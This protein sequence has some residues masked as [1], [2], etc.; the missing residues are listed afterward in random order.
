MQ[1]SIP[2]GK[3]VRLMQ[4][5]ENL[6]DFKIFQMRPID[7]ILWFNIS[8]SYRFRDWIP[9]AHPLNCQQRQQQ[10]LKAK[11]YKWKIENFGCRLLTDT[12]CRPQ[13]D[14]NNDNGKA[15]RLIV[16]VVVVV[17]D[18]GGTTKYTLFANVYNEHTYLCANKKPKKKRHRRIAWDKTQS[19][20]KW[21]IHCVIKI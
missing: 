10:M 12:A 17:V 1:Q 8:S 3:I 21:Q 20:T 14:E 13:S 4:K 19:Q 9:R 18:I 7:I 5:Y 11:K 15:G 2:N 16:V 6:V